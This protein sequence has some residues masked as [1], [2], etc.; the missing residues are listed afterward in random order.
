M[1]DLT[2]TNYT[3]EIPLKLKQEI[4]RAAGKTRN[5]VCGVLIG[6]QVKDGYYN[7]THVVVDD[8]A[9]NPSPAGVTRNTRNLY[10]KIKQIVE[11][12]D[13]G[14]ID[15]I[16][17]WHSHPAFSCHYSGTDDWAMRAMLV[18]P[19]YSFLESIILVIVRPS[20]EMRAFLYKRH[21]KNP[22]AMILT[23]I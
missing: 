9:I 6:K 16:G 15:Y 13:V 12:T 21:S 17:D 23:P 22:D 7:V 1:T 20:S 2:L 4:W 5:E 11:C 10:R 14:E 3:L 18:D 8:K 19:D